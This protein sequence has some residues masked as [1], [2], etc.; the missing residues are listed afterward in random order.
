MSKTLYVD[1]ATKTGLEQSKPRPF[2]MVLFLRMLRWIWAN[3]TIEQ[4]YRWE[5]QF[6]ETE[7][8][9]DLRMGHGGLR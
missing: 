3:A 7:E 8:A 6:L 4:Q 9:R 5:K 1:E 2:S